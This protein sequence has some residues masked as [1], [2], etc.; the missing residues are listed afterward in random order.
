MMI[1]VNVVIKPGLASTASVAITMLL[2]MNIIGAS[3][4]ANICVFYVNLK[5]V[6]YG[7]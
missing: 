4:I 3:S 6:N 7:V 1:R 2:N 5:N